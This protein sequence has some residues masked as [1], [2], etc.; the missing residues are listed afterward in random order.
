MKRME[1][2]ERLMMLLKRYG[3]REG[4]E[5]AARFQLYLSLLCRW[6]ARMNLAASTDW[7]LLG[8][9]FEEALWAA[10]RYPEGSR[11][12]LDFG[13]GAGFPAL[14]MKIVLPEMA[15]DLVESRRK[16]SV[17]LET[18]VW[19]LGLQRVAVH[20]RRLGQYLEEDAARC[21]DCVSWKGVRP[22]AAE[23][24]LLVGGSGPETRFWVFHGRELPVASAGLFERRF[25]LLRTE[26]CPGR[27]GSFLSIYAKQ[28]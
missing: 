24:E 28:G 23:L 26:A 8:P 25:G 27:R 15:L 5:S 9:L 20:C 17:F 6:N 1:M 21:W 13:S 3:L 11:S 18:V 2:G 19:E 7:A 16:K 4:S 14:A 10:G 12:H 22:S